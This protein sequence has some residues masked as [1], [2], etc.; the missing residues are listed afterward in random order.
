MAPKAK[1]NSWLAA[2]KRANTCDLFQMRRPYLSTSPSW[3]ILCKNDNESNDHMLL[4]CKFAQNTWAKVFKEFEVTGAL[5]KSW[6][7]FLCVDWCRGRRKTAKFL[8][9]CCCL[10]VAWCIWLEGNA[11]IFEDQPSKEVEVWCKIKFSASLWAFSS[12]LFGDSA[13]SDIYH[14]WAAAMS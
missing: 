3:C 2:W 6:F 11:R 5:P 14:N 7:D 8:W 10:A 4:R 12:N 1:K 9:R 13:I